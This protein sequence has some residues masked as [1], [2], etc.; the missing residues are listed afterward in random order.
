MSA[1]VFNATTNNNWSPDANWSGGDGLKPSATDT[2]TINPL[3]TSLI[4]DANATC[5]SFNATG[6]AGITISGGLHFNSNGSFTLDDKVTWTQSGYVTIQ[7]PGTVTTAGV[8]LGS[9]GLM[10]IIAGGTVTLGGALN[11]GTKG[12]VVY[13]NGAATTFNTAGYRVDCGQLGDNG[14]AGAITLTFGNS[15]INCNN[16]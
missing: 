3:V 2:V 4:I 13:Y 9:I 15:T 7:G 11:V 16:Y 10:R 1:K 12:I 6:T 8:S 14:Q 5:D